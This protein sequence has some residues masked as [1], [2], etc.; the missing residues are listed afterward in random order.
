M[1]S[2]FIRA[3]ALMI[4]VVIV[5]SAL[6]ARHLGVRRKMSHVE[7]MRA[8][9]LG[10]PLVSRSPF[11]PSLAAIAI[12]GVVPSVAFLCAFLVNTG[13]TT[14]EVAWV[15][16]GLVG[17]LGVYFGAKLVTQLLALGPSRGSIQTLT[18]R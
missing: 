13:P 18:T 5:P 2:D 15:A 3:F 4:P 12:G 9:E 14:H 17:G 11:W 10:H 6:L 8:I 1:M 16:A 7:R